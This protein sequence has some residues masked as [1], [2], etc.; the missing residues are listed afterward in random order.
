[1]DL[2]EEV[3]ISIIIQFMHRTHASYEVTHKIDWNLGELKRGRA[4]EVNYGQSIVI[5]ENVIFKKGPNKA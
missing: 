2:I 3:Y 5:V 1:M 4:V